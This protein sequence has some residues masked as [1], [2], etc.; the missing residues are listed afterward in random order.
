M[1]QCFDA[2][3][4]N[5]ARILQLDGYG[6]VPGGYADFVLLHAR[7]AIEALRLRATRLKVYRRGK[8][9]A[10]S[11][12]PLAELRVDGRLVCLVGCRGGKRE[13]NTAATLSRGTILALKFSYARRGSRSEPFF[14]GLP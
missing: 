2:A 8:L 12:A 6:I 9:L 11:P 13:S 4:V 1:R 3:T 14:G 7:D 10:Q 5:P